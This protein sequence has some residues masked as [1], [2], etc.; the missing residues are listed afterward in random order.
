MLD[1]Y[2]Y[3]NNP[4]DSSVQEN[5]DPIYKQPG[6][7]KLASPMSYPIT[8]L[9]KYHPIRG[10]WRLVFPSLTNAYK[11][12]NIEDGREFTP[13]KM[14][15]LRGS[16]I[17]TAGDVLNDDDIPVNYKTLLMDENTDSGRV[18]LKV[19]DQESHKWIQI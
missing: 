7:V 2:I 17:G 1:Y 15:I 14:Q 13:V 10:S 18:E 16:N 8:E 5:P 9:H 3:S 11:L 12:Q 6:F 19:Y 4:T